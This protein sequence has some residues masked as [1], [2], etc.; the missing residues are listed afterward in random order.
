MYPARL[1]PTACLA[2]PPMSLSTSLPA[3]D[4]DDDVVDH[5]GH[6]HHACAADDDHGLLTLS[7]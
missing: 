6:R 2:A 7:V 1:K 5:Y 3:V 4:H